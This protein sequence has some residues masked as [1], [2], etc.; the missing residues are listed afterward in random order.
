M[1][2]GL[3]KTA[4]ARTTDPDGGADDTEISIGH[5]TPGQQYSLLSFLEYVQE[6][7]FLTFIWSSE[8][9][10]SARLCTPE[11]GSTEGIFDVAV[12]SSLLAGKKFCSA[13]N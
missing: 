5:D 2:S 6:M 11:N 9:I 1:C 7:V 4:V 12:E 8:W 13:S 3:E 10:L